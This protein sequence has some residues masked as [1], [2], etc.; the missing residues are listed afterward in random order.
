MK[1]IVVYRR[2]ECSFCNAGFASG[3][4]GFT[5]DDCGA[6]SMDIPDVNVYGCSKCHGTKPNCYCC[7]WC[8][9]YPCSCY[10]QPNYGCSYCGSWS[11]NGE[12]QYA[13]YRC[14]SR[15]CN[16]NC[17]GGGGSSGGNGGN[18]NSGGNTGLPQNL[19][20]LHGEPNY[21][22]E[23]HTDA[24][25]R[26]G[27]GNSPE[28]YIKYGEKYYNEFKNIKSYLS[29]EGAEWVDET[30]FLLHEA[31]TDLLIENPEIEENNEAFREAAFETHAQAYIEGG[32]LELPITDKMRILF[33]VDIEDLFKSEGISQVMEVGAA[34][35]QY[36]D[37]NVQK[38]VS[39][40]AEFMNSHE[41]IRN[42]VKIIIS[43]PPHVLSKSGVPQYTD[44]EIDQMINI[45]YQ[46]QIEY[47]EA[48]VPN[49]VSPI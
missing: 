40:A 45:V 24:E 34:Q 13:C 47:F 3:N 2:G 10:T 48:N 31:I 32:I 5:C 43:L 36:W 16:G 6:C 14:G 44:A 26:L 27:E 7:T 30:A 38:G 46:Q 17:G 21:Y 11:C 39:E 15:Y 12:C 42:Q 8:N 33:T 20:N 49:F 18:E 19:S 28:Y 4:P 25:G 9:D 37:N 22:N 35:V 1:L 29:P 41:F 23:R